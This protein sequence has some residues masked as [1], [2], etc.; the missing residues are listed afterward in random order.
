MTATDP[1]PKRLEILLIEGLSPEAKHVGGLLLAAGCNL[2]AS[3]Q[4]APLGMHAASGRFDAVVLCRSADTLKAV[5]W[6]RDQLAP[7]CDLPALCVCERD[8]IGLAE[9]LAKA[10][11]D[12]WVIGPQDPARMLAAVREAMSRRIVPP[13]LDAERR[14]ALRAELDADALAARDQAALDA[15]AALLLPLTEDAPPEACRAAGAQA[16][17]WLEDIGAIHAAGLARELAETEAGGRAAVYR[18]LSALVTART[19]LRRDRA[20]G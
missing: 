1:P 4:H 10:G 17:P 9:T 16:A 18:V 7:A 11:V 5:T 20:R 6:L 3:H 19:A 8:E 13:K 12:A 2:T 14:A 15:A